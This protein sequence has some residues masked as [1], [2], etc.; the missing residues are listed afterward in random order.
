M[1]FDQ[2]SEMVKEGLISDDPKIV[3]LSWRMLNSGQG[4]MLWIRAKLL[5]NVWQ[6]G[7]GSTR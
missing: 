3:D 6:N 2:M 5:I 1:T 7:D 4:E